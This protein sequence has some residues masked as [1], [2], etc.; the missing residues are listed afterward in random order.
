LITQEHGSKDIIDEET[1]DDESD[2]I[3]QDIQEALTIAR[4]QGVL[5]PVRIARILAGEGSGQFSSDI[6]IRDRKRTIP[7]SVALDYVGTVL[8][9][10]RKEASRLKSEI[11]EYN[12]IC[13]SMENEIGSLLRV[14]FGLP[15]LTNE[16]AATSYDSRLNIDE[17]FAK[18]K[19]EEGGSIGDGIS[20]QTR[21]AF[22][23]EMNQT[24]DS[25]DTISRY[26]AKGSIG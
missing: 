22:W 7:L 8:E 14:S 16:E 19:S 25:F 26:F 3:L 1:D 2:E 20:E 13:N 24:E 6:L 21:E 9:K 17:L 15:P 23:R 18:I 10:S 12:Q 11:E 5:P 4:R